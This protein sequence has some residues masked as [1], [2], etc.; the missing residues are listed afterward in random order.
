MIRG[1][2]LVITRIMFY[3][4]QYLFVDPAEVI[5]VRVHD[6]TMGVSL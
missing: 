1:I 6:D 3:A 4:E 2:E 5:S